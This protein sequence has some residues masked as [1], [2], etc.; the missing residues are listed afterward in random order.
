MSPADRAVWQEQE[1]TL[2]VQMKP[3]AWAAACA[4]G[5]SLTAEQAI[6]LAMGDPLEETG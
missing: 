3:Q 4:R 6:A 1:A 5:Q 2:R